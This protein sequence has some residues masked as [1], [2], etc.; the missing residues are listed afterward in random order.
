MLVLAA[1]PPRL[2]AAGLTAAEPLARIYDLILDARFDEARRQL[3]GACGAA[4][5]TACLV[6]DAVADYWRVLFDPAD[7][8]R[9]PAVLTESDAAIASAEAWRAREPQRAEAWFYVGAAYGTRVLLRGMLRDELLA[10][11]RDGRRIHDALQQ[12]V[13][14]DPTLQDAYFGLGLYHYYAAVA[15][16]GARILRF[17]L[18]LPGG[19]RA[20]GLREMQQTRSAGIVLRGEADYQLHLI[21]LWYEHQPATALQL[22]DGLRRRHPNNPLFPLRAAAIQS[23]Y[24]HDSSASMQIYTRVLEAARARRVAFPAIAEVRARLGLAS[25][26]D[27]QCDDRA[28]EHLGAI[29]ALRPPAPYASL[30]RALYQT[31]LVHD[32]HGRRDDAIDAYRRAL[33]AV[34]ADDRLDLRSEVRARL[35]RAPRA[36]ACG[37]RR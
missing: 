26:L 12:A 32:R 23:E 21:Y 37:D 20:G 3:A 1:A 4:P 30:A 13:D 24:L 34:P 16:L 28:L 25:E 11:A 5:P 10:A 2:E 17:L 36:R 7:T 14:L 15:P 31:G 18:L 22:I 33:A 9:D 8:S 35:R 19:D 29:V 6:L 27:R